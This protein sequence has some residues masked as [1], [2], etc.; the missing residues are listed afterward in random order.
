MPDLPK[1]AETSLLY[2]IGKIISQVWWIEIFSYFPNAFSQSD[3]WIL[4]L[5]ISP[6]E[7]GSSIFV[8]E[9][10]IQEKKKIGSKHLAWY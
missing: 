3:L 8:V 1:N 6:V 5:A 10:D 4:W 9:I 2:E 7:I